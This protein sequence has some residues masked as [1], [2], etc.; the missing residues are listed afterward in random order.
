MLRYWYHGTRQMSTTMS[1][2]RAIDSFF[3]S[4]SKKQRKVEEVGDQ[5]HV[6]YRHA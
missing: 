4:A 5:K 6:K 2:K 3:P 1:R